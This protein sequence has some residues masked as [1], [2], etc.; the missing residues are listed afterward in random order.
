MNNHQNPAFHSL[1]NFYQTSFRTTRAGL[2]EYHQLSKN[3]SSVNHP[4]LCKGLIK[5]Q[6]LLIVL[7]AFFTTPNYAKQKT[8]TAINNINKDNKV[9][10]Y[11]SRKK[12][13]IKPLFD[14]F[15]KDTGIKVEYL[16]ANGNSLI[17][18]I[19]LEGKY[20]N[21]DMLMVVDAGNLWYSAKQ[22]LFSSINDK[23]INANIPSSLR[24]PKGLWTGLSVRARTIVYNTDRVKPYELSTYADLAS[25]KFKD[26]LCLRTSKKIY[27]KSLVA[28]ILYHKGEAITNDIVAGWVK[29]LAT[30]PNA[31]DSQVMKAI[32]A[33]QCDIGLVNTYYFVRLIKQNP[34]ARLKLF[35][36]NQQTT[37]VHVNITGAGIT[38][39]AKHK[40]SAKKLLIWLTNDKAQKIYANLNKEYPANPNTKLPKELIALGNF[41]QDK[42][43]LSFVGK[44]QARAVKIMHKNNYK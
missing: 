1:D 35:W 14:A 12:H 28:S 30:K 37:G 38:K 34:N 16:T 11:S 13:L 25:S 36:A 18:R 2:T 22:G 5:K 40:E 29:N 39:Y 26:R 42:M 17:E 19:K 31:K 44:L 10:V 7:L 33:K 3:Q 8:T 21:A 9:V 23:N 43:N 32:L 27:T 6:I 15:T 41:K 24:D 20:T 4:Y